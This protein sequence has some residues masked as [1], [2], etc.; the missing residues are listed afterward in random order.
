ICAADPLGTCDFADVSSPST[1]YLTNGSTATVIHASN[2]NVQVRIDANGITAD[3]DI[4]YPCAD[5]Q[6]QC[7][8]GVCTGP[9]SGT[10]CSQNRCFGGSNNGG[11][12]A[13]ASACPGGSCTGG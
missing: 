6:F 10:G 4:S 11:V 3:D 8:A 5:T 1:Y 12:C 7:I 9:R 2:G 13:T